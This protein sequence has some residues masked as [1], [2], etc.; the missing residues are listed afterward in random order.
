MIIIPMLVYLVGF[1]Q[2]SA[3]GTNLFI[4]LLPVIAASAIEYYRGGY[5]DLR[6]AV[7]IDVSLLISAWICSMIA[8]KS[9]V[10]I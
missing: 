2:Q 7:I 1:S 6:A 8:M 5:V 9:I 4:L 3:V 10:I